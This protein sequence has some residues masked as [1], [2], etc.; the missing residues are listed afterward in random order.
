MLPSRDWLGDII[1][2]SVV[3]LLAKLITLE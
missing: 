3:L 2:E 1:K